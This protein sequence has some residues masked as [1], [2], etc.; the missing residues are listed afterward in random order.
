MPSWMVLMERVDVYP[1]ELPAAAGGGAIVRGIGLAIYAGEWINVTGRNGSGKSTLARV[2]AGFGRFRVEGVVRRRFDGRFQGAAL[3]LVLQRPEEALI[4]S[5]PWED[6]SLTLEHLGMTCG[7]IE[8]AAVAALTRLGLESCMHRP[9][10]ELSGG[11]KQLTAAAGCLAS[12]APMLIL[13]E[14]TSMLDPDSS[15][16]VLQALRRLN[17]EGVTVLWVT[18]KLEELRR[19]DRLLAVDNGRIVYDGLAERFFARPA[20][21]EDFHQGLEGGSPCERT[22]LHPPYVV[23]TAWELQRLGITFADMPLTPEDLASEVDRYG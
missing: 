15:A 4:G 22:G 7:Q 18:Q 21:G 2:I 13:D 3:P 6:V 12:G 11:Q 23:E 16:L 17:G 20:I 10:A 8:K 14:A 5:T 19:G 9:F 1:P